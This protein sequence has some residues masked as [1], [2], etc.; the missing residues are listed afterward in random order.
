MVDK[1]AKLIS[2]V[3]LRVVFIDN[4]SKEIPTHGS[5]S[6]SNSSGRSSLFFDNIK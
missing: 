2:A 4:P 1:K 3:R 6:S 5:N